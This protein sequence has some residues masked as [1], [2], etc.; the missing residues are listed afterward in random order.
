MK[1]LTLTFFA[2]QAA[3]C[4][5]VEYLLCGRPLGC[6]R[7]GSYEKNIFI[8]SIID[9]GIKFICTECEICRLV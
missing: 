7:G 1:Q 6:S 4:G 8:V 3:C 9:N 2:V 5:Y